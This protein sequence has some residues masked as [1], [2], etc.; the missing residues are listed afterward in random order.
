MEGLDALALLSP[1]ATADPPTA[2]AARTVTQALELLAGK[3]AEL[4]AFAH[5]RAEALL[6]DHRR[7]REAGEATGKYTVKALLPADVIGL[8]V[9]LPKVS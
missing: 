2:V 4:D 1:A 8:Y 5:R 3:M 7:V 6:A 9:L